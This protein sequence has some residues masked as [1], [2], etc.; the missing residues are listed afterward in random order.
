[1][2]IRRNFGLHSF[3]T[4][5]LALS[6]YYAILCAVAHSLRK[7]SYAIYGLENVHLGSST[8]YILFASSVFSEPRATLPAE[9]HSHIYLLL[10]MGWFSSTTDKDAKA[11]E[12]SV[13]VS[14][15]RGQKILLEDTKPKF[16][17]DLSQ[18]QKAEAQESKQLQKVWNSISTQ[19]FTMERLSVIPCFRDAG[20]IGFSSMFVMGSVMFLYHKN[21]TRA[22]NWAVG[23]LLFGS[24]V[25]WEQCRTRRR[26]SFE[27]AERAR[28]TVATKEKPMTKIVNHDIEVTSQWDEGKQPY[29]SGKSWYKF[30]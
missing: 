10:G 7:V 11:D 15:S 2:H 29:A 1:M 12:P 8:Y 23:S 21:V 9:L 16:V 19:D 26:R 27:T 6:S 3:T 17:S 20:M 22:T 24:I 25:G 14:Y 5:F 4:V 28:A 30:W 18:S 13:P